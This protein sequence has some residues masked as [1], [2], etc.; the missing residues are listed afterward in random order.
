M[1][2]VRCWDGIID[3]PFTLEEI[4]KKLVTK[5]RSMKKRC[6]PK[7]FTHMKKVMYKRN[8]KKIVKKRLT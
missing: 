2:S 7:G 8:M 1:A 3:T 5:K 4:V 6:Q